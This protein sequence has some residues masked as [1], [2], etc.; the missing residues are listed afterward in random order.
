MLIRIYGTA[1][2]SQEK[3]EE[4]LKQIEEAK[5]NDHR[6]L[7]KELELF[8]AL[9]DVDQPDLQALH[10]IADVDQTDLKTFEVRRRVVQTPHE[11]RAATSPVVNPPRLITHEMT[12][13]NVS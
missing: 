11:T 10:P 13:G 8:L 9:D 6:K 3:L 7:G 5:E 1:F 4:H 12:F 2:D